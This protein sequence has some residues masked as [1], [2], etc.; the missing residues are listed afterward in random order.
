MRLLLALLDPLVRLLAWRGL[1]ADRFGTL[2]AV[3]GVA[4]GTATVNV[5]L[6]LDV[7][8]RA[9]EQKSYV[10]NPDLPIEAARTLSIRPFRSDGTPIQAEDAGEE[11]HEDYEIMRSAI[12]L[13][14]LSAFLVGA[15]I[16]FFTFG[17]AVE[18]RRREVALLR[19]LGAL[20]RQVA[21]VFLDQG[22]LVGAAGAA[23]GFAAAL[24]L[25]WLA[26][27]GGIT[28]TGRSRILVQKLVFPYGPMLL[29][30][31]IGGLTA[32]LGVI[33]PVREAL[34]VDVARTLRPR[35]VAEG[36]GQLRRRMRGATLLAL[37][38]T[39]L[40]YVLMR[41]FFQRSVPMLAFFAVEAGLLCAAFLATLL[42]VP[43]LVQRLGALAVRLLPRGPAAERLLLRRRVERTGH[44]LAW[45]VSGIMMVFA[46]LL[47]LHIATHALKAEVGAWGGRALAPYAFLYPDEQGGFAARLQKSIPER[48]AHARFSGRTPW[49]NAVLAVPSDEL[50]AL[51]EATGRPGAVDAARRL[52][53]GKTLVSTMMARRFRVEVGD[54]LEMEGRAGKRR[55]EVVGISD[56][57]GYVPASGA[58]RNLRTYAL[59]DAADFPILS[60][61]ADPIGHSI[62]M[63]D[64]ATGKAGGG[65]PPWQEIFAGFTRARDVALRTGP[66]LEANRTK[67]TGRDFV[68]FDMILAFTTILAAIGVANHMV[69]SIHARRRELGLYRVLGMTAGQ[70]RRMVLMEGALAGALGGVLAVLL[71]LPLGSAALGALRMVSAFEVDFHIPPEYPALVALGATAIALLASLYPAARAG[72]DNA[73]ESVHYE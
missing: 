34:R 46:L 37:P 62:A 25:A 9:Q 35:F 71:G 14:S 47:A 30:A 33:R 67:A 55:F 28:T 1:R 36:A 49:P 43:D 2:A 53:P 69:L 17:V 64:P 6:V 65:T 54:A 73:A 60:P 42:F 18:R 10:T 19:S 57:V 61:Y 52:G 12:R 38:F 4:L 26:A 27:K 15:L 45:S 39:V 59:V 29:V 58:Y 70:I 23:L 68:I 21:A 50:R 20:P 22:I 40:V 41:P 31:V 72:R 66:E 51:A 32:L 3:V 16:V 48:L 56:E 24:P 63:A 13:G 5:V 11:T 44:E 7:N 8:T